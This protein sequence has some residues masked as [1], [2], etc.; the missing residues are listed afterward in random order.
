MRLDRGIG[1]CLRGDLEAEEFE[2]SGLG[3]GRP[4]QDYRGVGVAEADA[5]AGQVGGVLHEGAEA[6]DSLAVFG[7]PADGLA[8]RRGRVYAAAQ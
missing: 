5:V 7:A 3:R 4:R 2:G 8:P 1:S 6:V